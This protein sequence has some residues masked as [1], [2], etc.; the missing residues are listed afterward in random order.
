MPSEVV[1]LNGEQFAKKVMMGNTDLLHSDEKVS[2]SQL[3]Q[4][5]LTAAILGGEAAGAYRLEKREKKALLGLRKVNTLFAVPATPRDKLPEHS[6][7]A[8]FAGLAQHLSPKENNDIHTMVYHW[9]REDSASPWNTV[10][11]FL[12][13]GMA[14]R[15]LIEAVEKKRLKIFT[16][17]DYS[18]PEQTIQLLKGQSP[19]LVKTLLENYERLHPENWQVL[20]KAIKKAIRDRTES[21]N[22]MDFD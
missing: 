7:E 19:N 6:L 5:V 1:F 14:K 12:K 21:S 22:D 20:E 10:M 3:A 9:L 11:E 13:A 16:V 4:A 17:I 8:T 2:L 15:G 18:L